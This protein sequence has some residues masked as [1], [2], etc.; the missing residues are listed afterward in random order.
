M[1]ESR[2][3]RGRGQDDGGYGVNDTHLRII[4]SA[5]LLNL[6]YTNLDS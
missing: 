6:V 4:Y 2:D 1:E 3:E 5:S